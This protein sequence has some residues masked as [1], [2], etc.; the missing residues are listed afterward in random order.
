M[1][2]DSKNSKNKIVAKHNHLIKASYKLSVKQQRLISAL[3]AQIHPEDVEFQRYSLKISDLYRLL[4]LNKERLEERRELFVR[5]LNELQRN[6]I[7]IVYWDGDRQL[8]ST[9]AWI[10]EPVFDWAGDSITLRVAE[11]LKPYLLQLGEK[12]RFATYRLSDISHFRCE[13]S[14]RFLEFCKN[15]EPRSDFHDLVINN[16][17]VKQ[18]I[19]TLNDLKTT[20]GIPQILYARP[21]DFKNKV[22]KPA[23]REVNQHTS[24]YFEFKM[25]KTGRRV[26]GVEL[27]IFGPMIAIKKIKLN[28]TQQSQQNRLRKLGCSTVFAARLLV[29]HSHKEDQVWQAIMA[30]EEYADW[31]NFKGEKLKFPASTVKKALFESWYSQRWQKRR[32]EELKEAQTKAEAKE[33]KALQKALNTLLKRKKA[34]QIAQEEEWLFEE[35]RQTEKYNRQIADWTKEYDKL[36]PDKRVDFVL[37]VLPKDDYE[38]LSEE[39]KKKLNQAIFNVTTGNEHSFAE[40]HHFVFQMLLEFLLP[41]C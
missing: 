31:L 15:S 22:L 30:V 29:E 27:L 19:Y 23:Q 3:I 25:L 14:F 11:S 12:G 2:N 10:E 26:T 33:R 24:A 32:E 17:F 5:I 37:N 35:Q 28:S 18:E 36:E 7:R 4:K 21:Y 13:Y 40:I 39:E 16:R 1:S 20:L 34:A 38:S 9:P 6:L 8:L 41:F